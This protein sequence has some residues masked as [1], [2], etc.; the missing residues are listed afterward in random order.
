LGAILSLPAANGEF[1]RWGLCAQKDINKERYFE[2]MTS[3]LALFEK[4]QSVDN[5][6]GTDKN[7]SHSYGDLYPQLFEPYQEKAKH[8]LEL[9]VFSGASAQVWTE[10]F[11]NA[12]VDGVDIT[13]QRVKFGKENPRITFHELDGTVPTTVDVF[14]GKQFDIIIDDA[15]HHP[16][17]QIASFKLFAPLLAPGGIFV[18]EDIAGNH[19]DKVK[20]AT[21]QIARENGLRAEW[22]D[23][24]NKKNRWDDIVAVFYRD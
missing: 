9:G 1:F 5:H 6:Y 22:H 24:R 10:Y 11:P 18:I 17:H 8:I 2:L 21:F 16:D 13:L 15:S 7:T 19:A 14:A 20:E 3:L 12:H 4:Y 23:L